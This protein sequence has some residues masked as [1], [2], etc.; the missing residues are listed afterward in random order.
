MLKTVL[1]SDIL[2]IYK[3]YIRNLVL[4]KGYYMKNYKK[5][6]ESEIELILRA[7]KGDVYAR[8][9]LIESNINLI[10]K[11]AAKSIQTSVLTDNDLIQEGIFGL[12]NAIEKFNPQ[13]GAKFSTYA[14]WWIKQAMFKAIS[15]QS[16]AFNVP[17]YIQETISRFK[18][19]KQQMEQVEQK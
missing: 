10:K 4:Q 6:N 19:T 18:K 16:Y 8:N 14:S 12:L 13:I 9:K 3:I 15:E 2:S 5:T 1:L 17:V 7:Q 11:I